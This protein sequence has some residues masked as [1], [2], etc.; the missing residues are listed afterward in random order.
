[1]CWLKHFTNFNIFR[2]TGQLY[3]VT[4]ITTV[5][6]PC[7][8]ITKLRQAGYNIHKR[9][10]NKCIIVGNDKLL[11]INCFQEYVMESSP[12]GFLLIINNQHFN[13]V[14]ADRLGTDVD[15]DQLAALF[16]KLG[17][18]VDVRHDLTAMVSC[19]VL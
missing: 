12:R 17:F 1:M 13:G 5:K 6:D 16:M 10:K 19:T 15:C 2:N 3:I 8:K 11:T 18:G 9:E 7:I 14:M 4:P